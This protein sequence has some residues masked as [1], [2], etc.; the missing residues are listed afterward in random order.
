[1]AGNQSNF[2]PMAGP[3]RDIYEALVELINFE[4]GHECN[5]RVGH[6]VDCPK[7]GHVTDKGG[8][9]VCEKVTLTN[10]EEAAVRIADM[11]DKG[12]L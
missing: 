2:V 12:E 9:V 5:H 4:C 11:I 10:L 7:C 6:D 8:D 1:M 3:V